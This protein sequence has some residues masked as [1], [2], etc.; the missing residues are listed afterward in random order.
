VAVEDLEGDSAEAVVA[1]DL[2]ALAAEVQAAAGPAEVGKNGVNRNGSG[3]T[4]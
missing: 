1:A 3:K 2:A 4:D